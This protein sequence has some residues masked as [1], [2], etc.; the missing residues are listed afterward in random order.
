MVFAA[1]PIG[2]GTLAPGGLQGSSS[3]F[4]VYDLSDN[5]AYW[6]ELAGAELCSVGFALAA[7][8]HEGSL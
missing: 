8:T 6:D 5:G 3:L 1:S 2:E 4:R 7:D